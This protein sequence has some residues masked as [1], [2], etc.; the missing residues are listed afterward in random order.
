MKVGD[1][2]YVAIDYALTLDSGEEVDRSPKGDPLGFII[3]AGQIIPGLEKRLI[4]MAKGDTTSIVV[5]PEEGY[6]L[7]Q[8]DLFQDIPKS[9]FPDGEDIQPGMAFEAEGPH[10]PFM[11]KVSSVN[12]DDT[13][14]VD[15]NHPLAGQRLHFAI[16]VIEVRQPSAEELA[17]A[18]HACGCGC[19]SDKDGACGEGCKCG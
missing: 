5:E 13:I 2:I 11:V 9:Q 12:A 18:S 16:T 17:A 15:L 14:T 4:G 19:H 8:E 6:G 1:K 7:V 3:G 10:G